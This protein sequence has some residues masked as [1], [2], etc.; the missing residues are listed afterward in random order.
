MSQ[1]KE[2][3]EMT[4]Q[5]TNGG[6]VL[7]VHLTGKLA[8]EDYEQFVPTVERLL[9]QH[10]KI[11]LLI[12]LHDFHGLTAG[13]LWRDLKFDAKHFH[14]IERVAMVG[15]AQWQHA[16]AVFSKPLT[17]A[18]VRYFDHGEADQALAWLNSP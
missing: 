6:K 15:E 8:K 2:L 18:K 14:D 9:K 16:M 11:R 4:L 1:I 17:A 7:E 13:A 12:E 5:E 3:N 10:G